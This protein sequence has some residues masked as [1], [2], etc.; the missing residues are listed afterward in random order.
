MI[1]CHSRNENQLAL[2]SMR[3]VKE[4]GYSHADFFR[5]L[6]RSMGGYPYEVDG[7]TV[8]CKLNSGTLTITLGPEGIRKL[9]LVEIPR[10]EIV[11]TYNNVSEEERLAFA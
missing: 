8:H 7:N 5:L 4:M 3:I 6:P 2:S 9:V 1:W 11:F 10:T